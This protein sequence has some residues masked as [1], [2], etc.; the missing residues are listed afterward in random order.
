MYALSGVFKYFEVLFFF[1]LKS[2]IAERLTTYI[3]H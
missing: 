1:L 3:I 2:D